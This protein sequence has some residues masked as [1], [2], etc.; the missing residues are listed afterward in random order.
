MYDI[1]VPMN[2]PRRPLSGSCSSPM[3][4]PA[5]MG[6]QAL[7]WRREWSEWIGVP[8]IINNYKNPP[9]IISECK[10]PP[11]VINNYKNPPDCITRPTSSR[12]G[13]NEFTIH[14]MV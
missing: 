8:D 3:I 7:D 14:T 4:T 1:E 11:N 6:L 12:Q 10:E 5:T 13:K 9:N 2:R